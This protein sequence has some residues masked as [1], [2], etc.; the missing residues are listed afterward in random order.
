MIGTPRWDLP[1]PS[2]RQPVLGDDVVATSQPL[3]AQAGMAMLERGG[4]AVDAALAAAIALAVVEPT[5]NG[6][7]GDAFAIVWDGAAL[8]GLNASGRSP[9]GLDPAPHLEAGRMPLRGGATVTVP[10]APSAWLAL[11]ERFG[12]LPFEALFV[13]A[14]RYAADGFPVSPVTAAAWRTAATEHAAAP[15]FAQ[16]FLP[17]GRVP[18]PGQR[19]ALP[20]QASALERIAASRTAALYGGELGAAVC[21]GARDAGSALALDDLAGHRADWV[22]ALALDALGVRVHE[23]PPNGQGIAALLALGVLERTPVRDEPVGSAG[24]LHWQVEATKLALAVTH[25]T[26]ADPAAM[27][28]APARLLEPAALDALAARI[29]PRHA[30]DPGHGQ[31]RP[32]GTVYLCSADRD[33]RMVSY[34]QSNYYGFGSGIVPAGTGVALANRGAGF[35]AR[36]GHPNVVAPGKRPFSTIIPG[37]VRAAD[38]AALLAFGVMGGPM[39]AQG[40]VQVLLRLA[41]GESLQAAL[42]APRWRVEAGLQVALEPGL[43]AVA[44]D[45]LRA[46]GHRIAAEQGM[47]GFGGAQAALRGAAGYVAA[48]DPRKDGQAIAR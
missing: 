8:H 36:A 20:E 33:G 46:R 2:A 29:D 17:G 23:L 30:R 24:W 35:S 13:P 26:V 42:D 43:A 25:D 31:P 48:S 10:G 18:A 4:N 7:G 47:G 37:F 11:S 1:Y 6:I 19:F 44:A 21:R 32:G 38:G 39:Q 14:V 40:H 3:A 15:G 27:R 22:E 34:I 5:S 45:G 41:A 9:A 16:A 28:V 12:A